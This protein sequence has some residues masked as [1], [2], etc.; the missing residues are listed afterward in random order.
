M[1]RRGGVLDPAHRAFTGCRLEEIAQL[2]RGDIKR[3]FG[4]DIIHITTKMV[5]PDPHGKNKQLKTDSA[6]RMVPIHPVLIE[7]GFLDY[8]AECRRSDNPRLFPLVDI[9][10][11]R[12]AR[13]ISHRWLAG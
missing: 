12:D 9:A 10:K 6:H 4:I 7:A 5:E 2:Q 8:V 1:R 11:G 3:Q 13:R